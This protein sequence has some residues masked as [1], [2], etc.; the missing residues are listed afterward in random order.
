MAPKQSCQTI[1]DGTG[2]SARIFRPLNVSELAISKI[3]ASDISKDD[4]CDAG[5]RSYR[6]RPTRLLT[7]SVFLREKMIN[8]CDVPS[9]WNITGYDFLTDGVN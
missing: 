6:H 1:V 9:T 5:R 3:N 2:E 4:A 8:R 7:F